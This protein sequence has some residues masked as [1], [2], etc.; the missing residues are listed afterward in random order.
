[1]ML[2]TLG[3]PAGTYH[4]ASRPVACQMRMSE[5]RM[6]ATP[7][8]PVL[9]RERA[10]AHA[11]GEREGDRDARGV[12]EKK[13]TLVFCLAR[14]EPRSEKACQRA[15][16]V[17]DLRSGS[18]YRCT[19]K[20]ASTASE[21]G[22]Q[23]QLQL[24]RDKASP[25]ERKDAPRTC[26]SGLSWILIVELDMGTSVASASSMAAPA[27]ASSENLPSHDS[28]DARNGMA[29]SSS[30]TRVRKSLPSLSFLASGVKVMS[31]TRPEQV[32]AKLMIWIC[33]RVRSCQL[34]L[35]V[36][37][38]GESEKRTLCPRASVYLRARSRM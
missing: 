21:R 4:R 34:D 28:V 37:L 12:A 24:E 31:G 27:C 8:P 11:A 16:D 15:G 5:C 10:S 26:L 17:I 9:H 19:R 23:G 22:E 36:F 32:R 1:M 3:S 30:Q 25:R 2:K 7:P 13:A 38:L 18:E 14:A 20:S 6:R 33:G 29:S 35:L